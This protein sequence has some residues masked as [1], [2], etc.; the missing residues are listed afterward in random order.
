MSPKRRHTVGRSPGAA[1]QGDTRVVDGGLTC[2]RDGT[3]TRL[4]CVSCR[5]AICPSCFVRT[6]IGLKCPRC[7]GGATVQKR[8]ARRVLAVVVVAVIAV[9]AWLAVR[10][11]IPTNEENLEQAEPEVARTVGIGEEAR[12]GA[13]TFNVT[14][15]ECS[16][17]VFGTPPATRTAQGRFCLVHL[18]VRND[19]RDPV[20]FNGSS[21]LLIDSE[22]RKY[23]PSSALGPI[24]RAP[25]A[26]LPPPLA[27]PTV[28]DV[29]PGSGELIGAL[30]NPGGV[31]EGVIV[32]DVP[33]T[34]V[35]AEVELHGYSFLELAGPGVRV[36]LA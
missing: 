11:G 32:F 8:S 22:A 12:D 19:G 9:A 24:E 35:P 2:E 21:Q 25:G 3:P 6:P 18:R 17:N 15:F 5:S 20:S 36:R 27:G 1:A 30:L 4:T 31:A 34:V 13:I 10:N 29:S 26:R 7:G 16:G 33:E 23:L 14:M 28:A